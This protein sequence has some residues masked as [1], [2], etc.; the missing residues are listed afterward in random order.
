MEIILDDV[1]YEI[2]IGFKTY[3][4]DKYNWLN[5]VSEILSKKQYD[6]YIRIDTERVFDVSENIVRKFH[7]KYINNLK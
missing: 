2:E 1:L 5:A 3:K 4:F 6:K 7:L